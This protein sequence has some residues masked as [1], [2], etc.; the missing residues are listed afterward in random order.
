M[1]DAIEGNNSTRSKWVKVNWETSRMCTKAKIDAE[2][3]GL[4][5]WF[6]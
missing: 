3:I 5:L 1:A 4:N 2:I 6:N